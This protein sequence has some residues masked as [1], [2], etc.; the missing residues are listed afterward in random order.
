ML[1]PYSPW[2]PANF[3]TLELHRIANAARRDAWSSVNQPS[4]KK[5]QAKRLAP[6]DK[7]VGVCFHFKQHN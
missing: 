4:A 3:S 5:T 7:I 1:W 2:P 6:C